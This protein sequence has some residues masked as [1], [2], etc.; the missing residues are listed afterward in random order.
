M[1]HF[2]RNYLPLFGTKTPVEMM[3]KL[4]LLLLVCS[5]QLLP[6]QNDPVYFA[7]YPCTT[8]DGKT[9]IF[10][11]DGD[12]WRSPVQGGLASRITAMEGQEHHPKVSPDGKWLAFSAEQYGN[13][14]VF[15][16][17]L[18]GGAIRQLTFHEGTDLVENWSWDS[19]T[20]Y[21]TSSR[22]NRI[23]A[24][25]IGVS[26]GT[27]K[28]LFE[29]YFNNIHNVAMHPSTGEIFFN[30][31]W[32]SSSFVHRQ[33]YKGPYNPDV[34]SYNPKTGAFRQ[35]TDF[36]GK[37]MEVT[38]DR[39][40]KIYFVSDEHNGIYNLYSLNGDQPK[41]LTNFDTPIYAPSVSAD[42]STVV[43]RRNY[44]IWRYDTARG[45]AEAV[46]LQV[47][48]NLT[49]EHSQDFKAEGNISDFNVSMDGKKI[50]L[51]SR[52]ELFVSDI[53]GQFIRQIET[54]ADGRVSEVFWLKDNRNILFNQTVGGYQNWFIIAGDGSGKA[55]QITKDLVN[56][57]LLTMNSERTKA[58]YLSG[59]EE[60]RLL[61]LESKT[62]KTL[63]RAELWGFQNDQPRFGPD[64]RHVLFTAYRN[65]ERDVMLLDTE[66]GKTTNLTQTG[67][68]EIDPNWSPDG[69]YVYFM[70]NRTQPAYPR[71]MQEAKIYRMALEKFDEPYRQEKFDE[72]FA[73]K[74]KD[75][76]EK[77]DST[78]TEKKTA[79]VEIKIDDN[80]LM[81]RLEQIGPRFGTQRNIFIWQKDNKT[82]ILY[83]SNHDEGRNSIWKTEME[84]F[85][86]TKTEVIKGANTGGYN[87]CEAKGKLYVM[88]GGNIYTLNLDQ[89]KVDKIDIKYTFRRE[90]RAEFDQ[91]F[92][93]T[94]ANME[95]NF[96]NETFHG[97]NWTEIRD[98]YAAYLPF[99]NKRA[100]L[101]RLLN[102]MLG[103]LNT[104]HFGFS[105][106]GDEEKA[107]LGSRTLATGLLFEQDNPYRVAHIISRGPA[108][109]K[110]KD[111]KVG[112][113]LVKING[114]TVDPAMNRESYLSKPSLDQ[115]L[116][117]GLK[118][119]EQEIEVLLHPVSSGA[120]RNLLY[121][122]WMDERQAIVDR[123]TSKRVAYV[124]MKNMGTGELDHFLEQMVSEWYSRE[125]LILDLRYNTGGNVHDAVLQFLSQ[126]PYLQW[127]YREGGMSPQPNFAPAAKP[128]IVLINEQSLSDAEM[129]TAGF[130]ALGL[131]TVIGTDTYR[132]IIFTSGK[133]LVDGS[134]YRLPSWGCY[135]LD[136]KNLEK[137]G[138][139]PDIYIKNTFQDRL[140]G[141]DPQLEKAI[142]EVMKQ[143]MHDTRAGSGK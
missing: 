78:K 20:I 83:I 36:E 47:G 110:D 49:L 38:I 80:G 44:Q 121:D 29:H 54:A 63:A 56:N 77:S 113:V 18:E 104:S 87:I 6:A 60:V 37:D 12:L 14:D 32:E 82:T 76:K 24:Y 94:W 67:V 143:L 108:D 2:L 120:E 88:F 71:G 96:Y 43:F 117:L 92:T 55:E 65:F 97:V 26:G 116:R 8:P 81:E 124:H 11:Y 45:K 95:E 16:M 101:R 19:Q 126:R 123:G 141:K 31:S 69:K 142:S 118:R 109:R 134:F 10:S 17:P 61:D 139:S 136:G 130:K 119:G 68:S 58:V 111:I 98:R 114:Q 66:T 75:E 107:Y 7:D 73:E 59:R 106:S 138:V 62:S 5:V 41:R 64:D 90:L 53:K 1:P 125:A 30:E 27:P 122:E 72:L 102:D 137:T 42:G 52:G 22:Y 40:G 128:I 28:R 93:E 74:D 48:R 35:Y 99:V 135:T 85:E 70:S 103:E 9:L 133:G 131:G 79:K 4:L 50:A 46:P 57:R 100:D 13:A 15:L 105:S 34:K 89:S 25:S 112:D 91:M 23:S 51:V 127:K 33:G 132:W 39:N 21:F 115:E 86:D 3:E 84:P 129:T 140:E